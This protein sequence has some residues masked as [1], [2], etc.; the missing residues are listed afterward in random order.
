MRTERQA[1]RP[2]TS[3]F[4][5]CFKICEELGKILSF[6]SYNKYETFQRINRSFRKITNE[7]MPEKL[8]F[9]DK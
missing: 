5:P 8:S 9:L 6:S 2:R 7:N 4:K 3:I 1:N